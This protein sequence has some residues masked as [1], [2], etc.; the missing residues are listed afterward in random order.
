[1]LEDGSS[2]GTIGDDAGRR[3]ERSGEGL[4]REWNSNVG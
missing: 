1:M 4:D 2:D 3:R